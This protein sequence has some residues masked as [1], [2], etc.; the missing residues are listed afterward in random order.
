MKFDP[1]YTGNEFIGA[2]Q[3][4][5]GAQVVI[6]GM[7][8]D[9]TVSFRSGTRLGPARVREV[10]IGLE[11]YSPYLDKHLEDVK[12]FD[13]GDIP[14][15]FGNP[16]RSLEQIE[17]FVD[18][19]VA[20]GKFPLGIGGEHLVTYSPL[21]ALHK[22]YPDLV[23]VQLDAH[24]DLREQYEGEPLSHS[25]VIRLAAR[26]FL[27]PKNIYQFGIRSG[28]REEFKWGREN[29]NFYPFKVLE[30][31]KKVLPELQGRPV[32]VTVD[33]DVLDPAFAPGT[34]TAEPGGITSAELFESIHA[35][36]G[37]GIN[38]VGFDVVEVAPGI[39]P[40]ELSQ[41]VASKLIREVLLGLV[42]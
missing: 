7:P 2:T 24:A 6:Y 28:T 40:S 36:A 19:I 13:A 42:K 8:M 14:L 16:G 4:Y 31:L 12:Y 5:E 9:W 32:Y 35:I 38:V 29:T 23:V 15:A 11:E 37:A 1:A 33:I 20:D 25:A 17:E 18:K 3:D 41:I 39:D 22:K 26:D 21:K 27:N 30:P 10:S 34:G